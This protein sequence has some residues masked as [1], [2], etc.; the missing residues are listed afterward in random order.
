MLEPR[1]F[2]EGLPATGG[3]GVEASVEYLAEQLETRGWGPATLALDDMEKLPV[4]EG[5]PA[6]TGDPFRFVLAAT[7]RANPAELSLDETVN[8]YA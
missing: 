2:F 5:G 4:G 1:A 6:V 8:I 3:L 7:G